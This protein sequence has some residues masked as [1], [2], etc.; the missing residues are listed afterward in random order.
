MAAIRDVLNK[1]KAVNGVDMAA[2]VNIDGMQIDSFVRGDMDVDSVCAIATTGLQMSE[3]LGRETERGESLQTVL[4]Y[5]G[6]AIVLE[7][8]ST[9]AM[10]LV[11]SADPNSIGRIRYMSKKYR[12]E[13]IDALNGE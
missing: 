5:K 6:G 3:A 8:L 10:M 9:E 12:Q 4:E 13:L 1:F 7:P 11:V 2:V